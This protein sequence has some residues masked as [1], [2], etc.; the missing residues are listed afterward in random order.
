MATP[1][2]FRYLGRAAY[3][4]TLDLQHQLAEA[5]AAD[6]DAAETFLAV[7][8]D[9]VFTIGR[10]GTGD[11]ILVSRERLDALGIDVVDV[12]R[13]GQVTYHGPGQLVI[14]PIV[15]IRPGHFGVSDLVRGLADSIR[16]VLAEE[17]VESRYDDENPGLW[18][19]D[20][21]ICSVGMRIRKGVSTHGAAVNLTTDLNAFGLI[22]PCGLPQSRATSLLLERGSSPPLEQMAARVAGRFANRFDYQLRRVEAT[23]SA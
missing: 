8:H 18:V 16:Q 20:R 13:G 15:R 7:E 23:T 3:R 12:D 11:E 4:P 2:H 17:G 5:L 21:K 19:D 14:Y 1:L 10:R 9:P 6:G 22:V